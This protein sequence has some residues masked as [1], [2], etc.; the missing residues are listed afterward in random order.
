MSLSMKI[1]F[2]GENHPFVAHTYNQIGIINKNLG[3]YQKSL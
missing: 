1:I 3:N 2:Y